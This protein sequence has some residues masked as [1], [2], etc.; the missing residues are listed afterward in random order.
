MQRVFLKLDGIKGESQVAS[1]AGEIEIASF[2]WGGKEPSDSSAV[3]RG[4]VV[5][6]DLTIIKQTDNASPDLLVASM[7][8]R[9]FEGLL[10]LEDFS[11]PGR[12]VRSIVFELQ[13]A[14]V[15]SV[16]GIENGEVINLSCKRIKLLR[17][18]KGKS[19]GVPVQ[20]D[21]KKESE[22][23]VTIMKRNL[24]ILSIFLV[25]LALC[26]TTVA[27][28]QLTVKIPKIKI[29]KPD[30]DQNKI[31]DTNTTKNVKTNNVKTSGNDLVY[32]PQMPTNVPVFLKNS[33]YVQATTT[34]EYWKMPKE[35][36]FSSWVPKI[37][38]NQYYN[39]EKVLN[40]TVEYF[41]PDGSVWYGEKLESSGRNGDRTVLY[42][43]P[44]PYGNG[45][46]ESKTTNATGVYSFKITNQD[47]KQVLFQG[48]FKVG[49]ISR[50]YSAQDKNKFDFYVEQ[51]WLLP[52]AMIGFHHSLDEVGGMSPEVSVW[53]KGPV[54]ANELEAR[55]F[56]KGQQVATTKDAGGASDYD[57][58]RSEYAAAFAPDKMWKRWEF[59]WRNFLFDNN[60]TF[61]RENFPGAFY[62]D[63]NPGDYTV[64]IYRSGTQ[65]RELGFT[66]GA[67]G[68]IVAPG[69]SSQIPLPYYRLI[70]PVKIIGNA[71]KWDLAA[72]KTD[73]FYGNPL[74]GF[75][76]K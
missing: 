55:V 51:D 47:T 15:D 9:R 39:E 8:G 26:L 33:I 49:K 74:T 60:G 14:A 64:K 34:D 61:N 1:H 3:G 23:E 37:R 65:I 72:W 29:E 52:F 46:L 30:K 20:R 6:S 70:L 59:S 66:V 35:R 73:A 16:A 62:A 12:M 41:N 44:S 58:R 4:N 50:A 25:V 22:T 5:K 54:E 40:Y 11:A 21:G 28:A 2:Y 43:S 53:L 42:Q 18:A 36:N 38:F 76:I 56:Y 32:T 68:R 69:Y 24:V 57:E 63:K 17:S 27:K 45:V 13:A 67:D 7:T 48:K 31:K 19:S 71:E 75:D 10:T